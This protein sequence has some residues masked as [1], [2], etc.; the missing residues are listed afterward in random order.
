MSAT[1]EKPLFYHLTTDQLLEDLSLKISDA[2]RRV[3]TYWTTID[4]K[5]YRIIP[6]CTQAIA[7]ALKLT[8]RPVQLALN[9]LTAKKLLRWN[10]SHG[11]LMK[12]DDREGEN[13]IAEAKISQLELP[14]EQDR[15]SERRIAKANVG[16]PRR[17]QDRE[18]G[19]EVNQGK[20]SEGHKII[21]Y[22]KN[23][24]LNIDQEENLNFENS[25]KSEFSVN[26]N[27]ENPEN[28]E[29]SVEDIR[30]VIDRSLSGDP[31]NNELVGNSEELE[32]ATLI[33]EDTTEDF[34]DE[35]G[36]Q[37]DPD[38]ENTYAEPEGKIESKIAPEKPKGS[39]EVES[40][41]RRVEDF[42][43]QTLNKSFPS[44]E[45]RAAY[46]RKF[47][48]K[49]WRKWEADYRE[50]TKPQVAYKPF[51]PEKV[52][53]AP[54]DSPVVKEAWAKIKATLGIKS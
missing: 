5:G 29:M 43:L 54:P 38:D 2:Q 30:A 35:V 49:S 32:N 8:R 48:A 7:D 50:A 13:L 18:R 1:A 10:K 47:D 52:E 23:K 15:Q 16:S 12:Y 4:P 42:V 6:V 27:F 28:L 9:A 53:V 21:N 11:L 17:T 14:L 34:D 44:E 25:E 24:D 3:Y 31:E 41:R 45:R 37:I 33:N 39:A 22:I 51:V 36:E 26:A 40:F 46:F 20:D 19:L